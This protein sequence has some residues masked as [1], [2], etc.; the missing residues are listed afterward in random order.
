M[1]SYMN[2]LSFSAPHPIHRVHH[3]H[4]LLCGVSS[5]C[6]LSKLFPSSSSELLCFSPHTDR[7]LSWRTLL[8]SFLDIFHPPTQPSSRK[9]T[10]M[11][12]TQSSKM[13]AFSSPSQTMVTWA[14]LLRRWWTSNSCWWLIIQGL[15]QLKCWIRVCGRFLLY[16][17]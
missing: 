8:T 13:N 7:E 12:S 6:Q 4:Q 16:L 3:Q 11:K 2:S 9:W 1:Q 17:H 15:A 14:T 10:V 5:S